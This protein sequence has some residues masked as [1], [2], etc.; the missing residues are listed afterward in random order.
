M[1]DDCASGFLLVNRLV[2]RCT[3]HQFVW[4]EKLPLGSRKSVECYS[5]TYSGL[6]LINTLHVFSVNGIYILALVI[7]H[8]G[9]NNWAYSLSDCL[10]MERLALS[11]TP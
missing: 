8:V 1:P 2:L 6:S 11:K 9:T 3:E 5:N 4:E 7:F 10:T